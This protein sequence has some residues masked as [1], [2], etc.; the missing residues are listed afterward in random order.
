MQYLPFFGMIVLLLLLLALL[1]S[2]MSF[3][4]KKIT[5]ENKNGKKIEL[6]VEIANNPFKRSF[7]LMFRTT[8]KE[9][10]GMLFVFP[11]EAPRSF[12][13]F[14]TKIPLD[15]IYFNAN[16]EVVD[17]ISMDPCTSLSCPTY[18]TSKRSKYVL[19][20]NKGFAK[21][22]SISTNSSFHFS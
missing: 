17:I 6:T 14:N 21:K 1:L 5:L 13:M 3:D 7:G 8:L 4:K 9:N 18:P 22:S 2:Q 19:E 10:E 16:Q 11:D 12:W 15:A 20:V